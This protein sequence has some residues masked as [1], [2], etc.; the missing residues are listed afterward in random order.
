[1]GLT[2][3]S[4]VPY[5][6]PFAYSRHAALSLLTRQNFS[7]HSQKN[8]SAI[9]MGDASKP[10]RYVDVSFQAE[11]IV[12]KPLIEHI[13]IGI[14]LSDP[15]FRGEYREKQ[16]HDDDMDDIIERARNMGCMKFMVTGSDLE[17]SRRAVE[18]ARNYRRYILSIL[19]PL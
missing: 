6:I 10:L 16:V 8:S 17:E 3:I 5:K 18:I 4:T 2:Y 19:H 15:V 1:M 13:Q 9:K 12:L 11:S 14:N 7:T